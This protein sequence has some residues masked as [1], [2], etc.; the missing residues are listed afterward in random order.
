MNGP[1]CPARG[2]KP[3]TVTEVRYWPA[4]TL[5]SAQPSQRAGHP[6]EPLR[7]PAGTA[8]RRP[9]GGRQCSRY[10]AVAGSRPRRPQRS[11]ATR[12]LLR[13]QPSQRSKLLAATT[14]R[15]APQEAAAGSGAG[16]RVDGGEAVV[17][18]QGEN[19][20]DVIEHLLA[21]EVA[22]GA[23]TALR[24]A[25][26]MPSSEACWPSARRRSGLL[27]VEPDRLGLDQLT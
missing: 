8:Q 16:V 23:G 9:D 6:A 27:P 17:G 18:E 5:G 3:A 7:R 2:L 26:A 14:R 15:P 25:R 13:I 1:S 19:A 12:P 11:A 21:A 24:L 4:T 20:G 22:A 10:A